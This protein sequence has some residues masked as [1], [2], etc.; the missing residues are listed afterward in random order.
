M[1]LATTYVDFLRRDSA[2]F[3]QALAD[4]PADAAVPTC[5]DWRADDL[6]WHLAEVQWFWGSILRDNLTTQEQVHG[7]R[8]PVRPGSRDELLARF[9]EYSAALVVACER[10]PAGAPRWMWALD[11]QWHTAG[12]IVRRQTH[13]ALIHRVDAELT[14]GAPISPTD[15]DL[16][17]DGIDEVLTVMFTAAPAWADFAAA[18]GA[19]QI[20]STDTD[21]RWLVLPGRLTGTEPDSRTRVDEGSMQLLGADAGQPAATVRGAAA[22]L[23]HWLWNRPTSAPL[24][25]DG[26]PAALR[27]LGD[28]IA[29]GLQ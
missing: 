2:R 16:A 5:P 12:Y 13:E 20:H 24:E 9:D 11:E 19:V 6:L 21:D 15:A 4:A 1:Q 7:L 14:A 26:D 29:E 17:S 27:A 22:D 28:V 10:V 23:D 8:H 25:S 3:R 18:S